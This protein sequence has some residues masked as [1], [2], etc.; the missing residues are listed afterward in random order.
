VQC[1]RRFVC[2]LQMASVDGSER[3][4]NDVEA[5][6]VRC[7]GQVHMAVLGD[8]DPSPPTLVVNWPANDLISLFGVGIDHACSTNVLGQVVCY[9]NAPPRPPGDN[10]LTFTGLLVGGRHV[11]YAALGV[12]C[13]SGS[14]IGGNLDTEWLDELLGGE[15]WAELRAVSLGDAVACLVDRLGV[16]RCAG[17]AGQELALIEPP[18][19]LQ[20]ERLDLVERGVALSALSCGGESFRNG[21]R[22]DL[23]SQFCCGLQQ[24]ALLHCWGVTPPHPEALNGS[25]ATEVYIGRR[26]CVTEAR[27]LRDFGLRL[28]LD[29]HPNVSTAEL[30]TNMT[31]PYLCSHVPRRF[32]HNVSALLND[33]LAAN[34]TNTTHDRGEM[35]SWQLAM[36]LTLQLAAYTDRLGCFNLTVPLALDALHCSPMLE[37]V[38]RTVEVV[39]EVVKPF[40]VRRS[41]TNDVFTTAYTLSHTQEPDRYCF[42][43]LRLTPAQQFARAAAWHSRTQRVVDGFETEFT[44]QIANAALLCQSVRALVTKTLLYEQAPPAAAAAAPALSD[45]TLHPRA[46]GGHA[47][48]APA[49]QARGL[50][51]VGARAA[52]RRRARRAWPRRRLARVRRAAADAGHRVRLVAEQ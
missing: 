20:E 17:E 49:V 8:L 50:R 40:T 47:P 16:T 32:T 43:K 52:R 9:G 38:N 44:F 26:A 23:G 4:Y 19:P 3:G 12:R 18:V 39:H 7:L 15:D 22:V 10:P 27:Y 5:M 25:N 30:T 37:Y 13:Y 36:M 2:V 6:R 29:T 51:R 34:I 41:S 1:G 46:T 48:C 28:L 21:S 24:S 11:C 31:Q 45:A 33:W 14:L 35:R 42:E